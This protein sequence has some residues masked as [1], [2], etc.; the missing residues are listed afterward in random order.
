MRNRWPCC[1]AVDTQPLQV[2]LQIW[3]IDR[4]A[5]SP[6][7]DV[8]TSCFL[9]FKVIQNSLF[10]YQSA[11][12][13]VE[14]NVDSWPSLRHHDARCEDLASCAP[15]DDQL[16]RSLSSLDEARQCTCVKKRHRIGANL[17]LGQLIQKGLLVSQ[18]CFSRLRS[19]TYI[20]LHRNHK[21]PVHQRHLPRHR[22]LREKVGPDHQISQR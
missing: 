7:S 18:H 16:R 4:S 9:N 8:V 19:K 6:C 5:A 21:R 10:K 11:S 17:C 2:E 3:A 14:G 13:G 1:E 12:Q 22:K 15:A 20:Y